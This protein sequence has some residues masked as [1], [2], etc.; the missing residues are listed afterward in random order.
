MKT[1]ELYSFDGK[2]Y[3]KQGQVVISVNGQL[4][5]ENGNVDIDIEL[6]NFSYEADEQM[7][8]ISKNIEV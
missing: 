7:L 1:S 8:V 4:P 5:D 2:K 3:L 6:Y